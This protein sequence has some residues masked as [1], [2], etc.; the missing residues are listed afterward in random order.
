MAIK[1][2]QILHVGHDTVVIDRIQTAGPGTLNIPTEKI[3][4]LGN[5]KSVATIRDVPDLT[6]SMESLDVSTE[7]EAMLLDVDNAATSVFDLS[8]AKVLN[9]ASQFKA[10]KT[11]TNEFAI[12]DSVALPF[13]ALES[14]SYRFGLRDN[15]RQT[16]GLRG[17]SIFYNPGSTFVQTV[18]GSGAAGQVITT[19]QPAYAT[20]DG[21]TTRRILAVVAGQERLVLGKDYTEAAV[22]PGAGVTYP[23]DSTVVSVTLTAAV[24]TTSNIRIVYASPTVREY[25]QTVHEGTA[26]KPAAVRGKDIDIYV[27]GY[28]PANVAGSQANKW[29]TVQSVSADFRVTLEKDE[30]FGNYYAVA[31]DFDVP[32][33]TGSIDLKPLSP[34]DL[35][36]RLRR[37][38]GVTSATRS[39]GANSSV[40]LPLDIVIKDAANGNATLKRLHVPD[41]RFT[42]PGFAGRTQTKM[43]VTMNYESDEGTLLVYKA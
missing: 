15:A 24:P 28:D 33:V 10:G 8:K 23:T 27:G 26:I 29:G 34:Q 3:Y 19:A 13:L 4:E 43:T 5:Y 21:G 30:E 40:A 35:Q 36:T 32:A 31:N 16:V 18:A 14:V 22:A 12:V 2:G 20:D 17:D 41:A 39:V 25:Q 38:S 37:I 11:A 42:L 9:L 1:A 6:F 7:V